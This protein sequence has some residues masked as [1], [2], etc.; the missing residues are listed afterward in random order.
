MYILV[1]SSTVI[2]IQFVG[3]RLC[4]SNVMMYS[5]TG[6]CPS[7]PQPLLL[8][9]TDYHRARVWVMQWDGA[10]LDGETSTTM[11]SSGE[12]NKHQSWP[13]KVLGAHLLGAGRRESARVAG[14]GWVTRATKVVVRA[15]YKGGDARSRE[16]ITASGRSLTRRII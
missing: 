3:F 12:S 4:K 14:F 10:R 9:R 7:R 2:G 11:P 16:R 15:G 5:F 1:L 13:L 6:Q 8:S